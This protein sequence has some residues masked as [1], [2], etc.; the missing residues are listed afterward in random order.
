MLV[1][2]QQAS[3]KSATDSGEPKPVV[4]YAKSKSGI[5]GKGAVIGAA[6]G[7]G[8]SIVRGKSKILWTLVGALIGSSLHSMINAIR[9]RR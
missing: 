4:S 2:P 1:S 8:Y 5:S 6:A 9:E 3:P 7:F